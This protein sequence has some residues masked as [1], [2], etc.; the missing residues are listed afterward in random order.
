MSQDQDMLPPLGIKMAGESATGAGRVWLL[1]VATLLWV[2]LWYRDTAAE[3]AGIWWRSDTFAHGLLVLPISA[4]L[5]W[6]KRDLVARLAP[7]P[8]LVVLPAVGVAGF[9]W[10]IG[11]LVSASALTH[12]A[13]AAI[14]VS[15]FVA[16][17]GL[18]L[19]RILAFPLLFLFFGVPVGEFLLPVLM[20]HTADFTVHALRL[21]GIPVYRENLF[22][23]VP[24][25]RWSV[26]EACSGLRYLVASLMVGSLY[27]YLNYV[28]LKRRLLFMLVA[29]VVPIV[30]NW[31]RAY[32]TVMIGYLFGDDFVRGFV[33]IVYGWVFFGVVVLLMF[34]IGSRWREDLPAAD[35]I[36][37]PVAQGGRGPWA[38][39]VAVAV[40]VALFP[41][42][43]AQL[44]PSGDDAPVVLKAPAAAA[45]WTAVPTA[46]SAY[47]PA[48]Q[49]HRGELVQDYRA[50]DGMVL[51]LYVAY[52]A[53]QRNGEEMVMSGNRMDGQEREGWRRLRSRERQLGFGPVVEATLKRD[54]EQVRSWSWY[55][56]AGRTVTSPYVAKGLLALDRLGGRADDSAAVV[57]MVPGDEAGET[58]A[59]AFVRDHLGAIETL[60]QDARARR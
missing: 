60:L 27:A 41:L 50:P 36:A 33:H 25:G 17:I 47:R 24:N 43:N 28:S 46:P 44:R 56:I 3:M 59:Q 34:W 4:W 53:G 22:F 10:L 48:F 39:I 7:A 12:T 29:L 40:V 20:Q 11:A 57:V 32:A 1:L 45:G 26:V 31:I 14:L 18:R 49:G 2:V 42:A 8:A 5:A 35:A 19:A 16:V 30:A 13:L 51:R 21:T 54:E 6:R 37:V 23:V 58:L 9:A 38:G 52:Y 55:W 15:S